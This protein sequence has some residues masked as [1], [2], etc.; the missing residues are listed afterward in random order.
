VSRGRLV[1]V[2]LSST[3]WMTPWAG[4]RLMMR[5]GKGRKETGIFVSPA[6]ALTHLATLSALGSAASQKLSTMR[7]GLVVSPSF[8]R[9]LII[10]GLGAIYEG[11]T[12]FLVEADAIQGDPLTYFRLLSDH[13][14]TSALVPH[15]LFSEALEAWKR[16]PVERRPK[17][18]SWDL[19]K[20]TQLVSYGGSISGEV[21]KD[22]RDW[23]K[24]AGLQNTS[25]DAIYGLSEYPL[26]AAAGLSTSSG[27]PNDTTYSPCSGITIK[28]VDPVTREEL[29]DGFH[30]E[31]WVDG[32]GVPVGFLT[33]G[34][35]EDSMGQLQGQAYL[36]TGDLGAIENGKF[37]ISGRLSDSFNINGKTFFVPEIETVVLGYHG[38]SQALLLPFPPEAG[39]NRPSM[40][41]MLEL[42]AHTIKHMSMLDHRDLCVGLYRRVSALKAVKLTNI[43][44]FP[45]DVIP[46]TITGKFAKAAARSLY[47]RAEV[48]QK[49]YQWDLNLES[50]PPTPREEFV[51]SPLIIRPE[52]PDTRG[53]RD[54]VRRQWKMVLQVPIDDADD[55][56]GLGGSL[57]QAMR[58]T[59]A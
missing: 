50:V 42:E 39:S 28:V 51:L 58:I 23:L 57:A 55:F 8:D 18:S 46:R 32:P 29:P 1:L 5:S 41:L 48:P 17:L 22:I 13:E 21:V 37:T 12:S 49:L 26:V 9:S 56:Y 31:I 15:T 43:L 52:R 47:L 35:E 54:M 16:I 40:V 44:I 36:R 27:A 53:M 45:S 19:S 38:V 24:P 10:G 3:L 11:G 25:F 34:D 7:I 20:C 30:G 33:P 2:S 14:M 6:A 4:R 59:Y